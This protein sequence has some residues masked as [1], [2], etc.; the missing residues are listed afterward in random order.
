M[1]NMR[2]IR[3]NAFI[4][5]GGSVVKLEDVTYHGTSEMIGI[6][7]EA[8]NE[9]LESQDWASDED[10]HFINQKTGEKVDY[11]KAKV[12]DS[13]EEY[14]F[15]EGAQVVQFTGLQDRNKVDIFEDDII[16]FGGAKYIVKW[17]DGMAAF[18]LEPVNNENDSA[19]FGDVHL[20]KIN[21]LGNIH[22]NP[23]L[24]TA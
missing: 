3:F 18:Y 17:H 13:G 21:V 19:D 6:H 22:Q 11:D 20:P 15:I 8:L 9:Q 5:I 16:F 2:E 12:N 7:S 24:V 1:K 4:T 14:L 23:E 10:Y